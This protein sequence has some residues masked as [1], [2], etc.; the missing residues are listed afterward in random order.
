MSFIPVVL[1]WVLLFIGMA[2]RGPFIFYLLFGSMSFGSFAVIPPELTSGLS[3]TPPPIIALAIIFIYGGGPNGLSRMLDIALRPSQC[4]LLFL[5]WIVAIWVTLFMPR[6]F[7]GQVT[8]IPMRLE[9]VSFGDPL[10]PTTQN[11][12]QLMYL[13]IS[14]LM[15]FACS[16]AF[17]AEAASCSAVASRDAS[18]ASPPLLP[19]GTRSRAPASSTSTPP[20]IPPA[21][22]AS[23][24]GM[25]ERGAGGGEASA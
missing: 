17:R 13:T 4:L 16:L 25:P 12:S 6:I 7:A 9:K 22:A 14:I 20:A 19:S 5:F 1:F 2:R 8:I 23:K 10:F 15:V 21:S 24:A 3:F 18:P 11:I